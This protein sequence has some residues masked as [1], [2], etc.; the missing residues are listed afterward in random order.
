MI[1]TEEFNWVHVATAK[2][3]VTHLLAGSSAPEAEPDDD[4]PARYNCLGVK[5]A[6]F[7]MRMTYGKYAVIDEVL[8]K[9]CE[10]CRVSRPA[11]RE[12]FYTGVI[13]QD[14]LDKRCKD[15]VKTLRKG[16]KPT[17]RYRGTD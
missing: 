4:G 1:R 17:E 9:R 16:G 13:D 15:C 6:L 8:H 3:T 10:R 5:P 12:H 11:N 2:P 14:G 7:A